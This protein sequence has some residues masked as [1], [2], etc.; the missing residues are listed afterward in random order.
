M[1]H[2]WPSQGIPTLIPSRM[3][4]TPG[5]IASTRPTIS[6]PRM[7]GN[8]ALG[9]SPS[10]TCKSVR[11]TPQAATLTRIAP[12]PGLGSGISWSSS[13]AP[14]CINTIAC[15]FTLTD[16]LRTNL[17]LIANRGYAWPRN[18]A[19]QCP[20]WV[21]SGHSALHAPRPL[22]PP[23]RTL[24]GASSDQLKM[25]EAANRGGLK[26]ATQTLP[27]YY[28]PRVARDLRMVSSWLT[29]QNRWPAQSQRPTSQATWMNLPRLA[30]RPTRLGGF[31]FTGGH[32][33]LDQCPLWV[34]SGLMQCNK[35]CPL[36]PRKRH[37]L[38]TPSCMVHAADLCA[39]SE[40]ST[41]RDHDTRTRFS[42]ASTVRFISVATMSNSSA[43]MS[44]GSSMSSTS[45]NSRPSCVMRSKR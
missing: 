6:W 29:Q 10:T 33:Y 39:S 18:T 2:V 45:G 19:S 16:P 38:R 24:G 3:L 35:A 43:S 23:K 12:G 25:K 7:I 41:Q 37:S 31:G 40:A 14:G 44:S 17:G 5:P 4:V 9:N 20:L 11:H 28:L 21:I 15:K 36:Y 30:Q 26:N 8:L 42:R 22:Y 27:T 1:P 34:I 32:V 13:L